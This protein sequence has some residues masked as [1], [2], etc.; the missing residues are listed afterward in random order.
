MNPPGPLRPPRLG[1]FHV[2]LV[3]A[4]LAVIFSLPALRGSGRDLDHLGNLLGFLER[5]VPP[6]FS[7]WRELGVAL[8][9][10]FQIAVMATL[11]ATLA[12]VPVAIAASGNLA[13]RPV[14]R[15]A[16]FLLVCIRSIPSLVWALL[17]VAIF[18]AN[19]LAGVVGLACYSLGYL[20]KFFSDAFESTDSEVAEG[21]RAVGADV[22]QR[23]QF[24]IWPHAKPLLWSQALWMLEYNIRSAAII[25]YVGAGGIGVWLQ[26]YQELAQWDRFC[27]V[28]CCILVLVLV[29]DYA[30]E[31]LR[32]QFA[33]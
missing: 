22:V 8:L 13:P 10:T 31:C 16:R 25:G 11:F 23:F 2:T 3:V 28:L 7:N 18:G 29:L 20:G 32:R 15:F 26:T 1:A 12:A 27:A 6:D 9:E 30:G 5:F 17:A 19:P 33:R 24:G 21:L 14:V 4:L